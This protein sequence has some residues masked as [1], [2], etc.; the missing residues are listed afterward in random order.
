MKKISIALVLIAA[1]GTL[2]HLH[3]ASQTYR[4]VVSIASPDGLTYTA[5]LDLTA[6]RTA[7]AAAN[8]DYLATVRS[9]CLDCKVVLA[10][11]E[12]VTEG[13]DAA[14]PQFRPEHRVV[15]EGLMLDIGG[16]HDKASAT[17]AYMA[18][19]LIRQGLR[20]SAC[21]PPQGPAFDS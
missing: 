21:L 7:C 10:R 8:G 11:C 5:F 1:V 17:C 4:P 16:P 20:Q 12:R 9:Q 2:A 6:E 19:D 14:F 18:K 3:A 13:A 15:S